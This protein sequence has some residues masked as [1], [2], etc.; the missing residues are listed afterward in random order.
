MVYDE[1]SWA[2]FVRGARLQ[3][4]SNAGSPQPTFAYSWNARLLDVVKHLRNHQEH[5]MS[6]RFRD[7]DLNGDVTLGDVNSIVT[8]LRNDHAG[9]ALRRDDDSFDP[10][11]TTTERSVSPIKQCWPISPE[12][13][14]NRIPFLNTTTSEGGRSGGL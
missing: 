2:F 11:T 13:A 14:N 8:R 7:S 1:H 6:S 9:A 5:G 3:A 4:S 10:L 12:R